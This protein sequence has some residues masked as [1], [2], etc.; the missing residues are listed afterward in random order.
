MPLIRTDIV[1]E[2]QAKILRLQ[3]FKSESN[4]RVDVELGPLVR[5]FPNH[6]FP[7]GCVHEFLATS[8]E[9]IA[10]TTAFI[11]G[12]L[13]TIMGAHGT[14]LWI[15]SSRKLF[16]PALTSFGVQPDR[17]IFIDL[18]KEKDVLWAMDEALKCE[19]I[20]AV[21]GELKEMDF[22]A[23]RRLQLAVEKS[24]VTGFIIRTHNRLAGKVNATACVSRWKI[25]PLPSVAVSMD[26]PEEMPGIGFPSWK[27][28]LLRIRNGKTGAW[29]ISWSA[30]KFRYLEIDQE[31]RE[32]PAI[33]PG[34]KTG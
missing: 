15:S 28:E 24:N 29:N 20:T 30:G 5:C 22:T 11:S 33:Y 32:T 1:A 8:V 23:S 6:T 25:T 21:V 9:D 16:P 10:A 12:V 27:V 3:G 31:N 2:L 7:V 17:C 19:A 26:P 4:P 34:Q 13:A 18:A 14:S